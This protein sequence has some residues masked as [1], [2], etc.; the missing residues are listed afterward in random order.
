V[1]RLG[2]FDHRITGFDVAAR[3]KP[4]DQTRANHLLLADLNGAAVAPGKAFGHGSYDLSIVGTGVTCLVPAVGP[5]EA[6]LAFGAAIAEPGEITMHS[7]QEFTAGV[8]S[9][10]LTWTIS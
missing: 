5:G 10:L 1:D 9:A 6:G 7:T 8:P 3:F 4:L 2:I